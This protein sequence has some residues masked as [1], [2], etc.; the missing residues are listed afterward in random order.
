MSRNT[1]PKSSRLSLL[2]TRNPTR[3]PKSWVN[4]DTRISNPTQLTNRQ[5]QQVT[6]RRETSRFQLS[7]VLPLL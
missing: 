1:S 2:N 4:G 3:D 5:Y 7:K 6:D